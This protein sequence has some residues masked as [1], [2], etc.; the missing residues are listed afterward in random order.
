MSR[1]NTFTIDSTNTVV[2]FASQDEATAAQ[3]NNAEYFSSARELN[4]VASSWPATRLVDVWNS[5]AGVAP[6]D[7][8]KVVKKFKDRKAAVTRIWDAIQRLAPNATPPVR[9]VA[10]AK[11]QRDKDA[12]K[13]KQRD[14]TRPSAQKTADLGREG[15]KK[16]EILALMRS[17][18]GATLADIGKLTN[19]QSH[20]I[21]GFVSGT[22]IKKLGL[23]VKSFRTDDK[24]RCYRVTG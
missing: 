4:K 9:Y 14:T 17:P 24:E 21:R 6:F 13:G 19:W 11:V 23:K 12:K 10:S 16:A 15:S 7:N 22:L 1:M 5:F 18:N 2:A 8:L 3:I 20:T